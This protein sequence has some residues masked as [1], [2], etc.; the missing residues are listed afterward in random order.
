MKVNVKT[1][2]A[3]LHHVGIANIYMIICLICVLALTQNGTRKRVTDGIT[4][5]HFPVRVSKRSDVLLICF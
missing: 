1:G 2:N 3:H 5:T 4:D